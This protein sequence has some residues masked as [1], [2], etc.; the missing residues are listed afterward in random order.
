M[1]KIEQKSRK[2]QRTWGEVEEDESEAVERDAKRQKTEGVVEE[3][4][5]TPMEVM[6]PGAQVEREGKLPTTL[7]A[8]PVGRSACAW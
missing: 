7:G 3:V 5:E 6:A 2:E 1:K 8:D 4:G